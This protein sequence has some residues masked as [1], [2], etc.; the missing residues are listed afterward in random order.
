M[1]ALR[2]TQPWVGKQG[3][4]LNDG[5]GVPAVGMKNRRNR[6]GWKVNCLESVIRRI[7]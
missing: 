1:R 5:G 7:A 3:N 6:A 2:I 4:R